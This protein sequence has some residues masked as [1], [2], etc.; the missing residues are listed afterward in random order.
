[1]KLGPHWLRE[2]RFWRPLVDRDVDDELAFHLAMRAELLEGAGLDPQSARDAALQRF[3]D[4]AEV[5]E[6]CI[7]MSHER[8]RRMKRL[9]TWSAVQ[10]HV[11]FAFR[12]LAA[13]PGFAVAVLLMLAL[14]IGATTAV[15]CVV[16]GILLRPLP[17]EQPGQLVD[18]THS[19]AVS[20]RSTVDQ[21]D[22]SF[23]LYRRYATAS[24]ENMGAWRTRGVN[25]GVSGADG[26]PERVAA[27]GVSEGFFP[28]LRI[29][30]VRG[31]VF[32]PEDDRP[33]AP[34]V[35]ILS[36]ALWQ[37]KF[38][39][40]SA[41][42]ER[43]LVVD[44]VEREVVGVM[45]ESF[46]YPE[47]GTSVWFPLALDPSRANP[48]SFNYHVVARL[49]PGVERSTATADLDRY[50]PRLLD[51]F[52]TD[53]PRDM[54]EQAH[55]HP[56]VTP[57]R[58]AV[59]GDVGRLLWILLGAVGL[60]LSIACANVASLFLV[61]AEGAR[62]DLAI[63]MAL[64]AGRGA[65]MAQY[66]SEALVLAVAGGALGVLFAQLGVHALRLSPAGA[67]LP[68]LAEVGIDARVL[69]FAIGITTLSALAVS[70]LPVV[71]SR[72]VA[73]GLV[74]KEASRSATTGRERQRARSTLVVAQ[75][76]LALVLV[77]GSAL[78]ARSFARLRD[79]K[80]GFDASGVL[81]VRV[82]L[83]GAAYAQPAARLRFFE[84][85]LTDIRA[86]PGVRSAAVLDWVPLTDDHDDSVVQIE[87][88]P[89]PAGAVPP[90]LPLTYVS[91]DY[92]ATLGVPLVMGRTF[93][94]PDIDRPSDEVV[95]S[96]ALADR[97][98]KDT[99]PLGKRLRA[100]LSGPWFTIIGVA[101]DVHMQ[102]L[103]LPPEELVYFSI[104]RANENQVAV[105]SGVALAVR[106]T[107][108]PA[109]ISP[110]LRTV[111]QAIDP[112]LPTYDERSMAA[113]LAASAARTRFVMLMLGVAS[114]VAL[115]IGMVGLYGVLAYGVTLRRREIGVRLALGATA[116][117]VTLMVARRG[118]VLA[119][120]G[121]GAG[122]IGALAATRVLH[123]LLYGVSPTDPVALA[124]TCVT[125]FAVAVAASWLPAR[126]AAAIQPMEALRRD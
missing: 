59:V 106:T 54:W 80:P 75:V 50:L 15:F 105:P 63:R 68:R 103:E 23:L 61:R 72:R 28:T 84:R 4:L 76:A 100:S 89:L 37:R 19:I 56:V 74:L 30:P 13:A 43:R 48:A 83:S 9:E 123:G 70:L 126:R 52:P 31:R 120:L 91:P 12:R 32:R 38:G 62:R 67:D 2:R 21:S 77:A 114:L 46:R 49:R 39:S 18:L 53:I 8:E 14:G 25:L 117:D 47:P 22:G 35:M 57:L 108:D 5:R 102:S 11:R 125:L 93:E 64:G 90:D 10:Q 71:R 36:A 41:I 82:A 87:D 109:A 119:A 118:I 66:L 81:T 86:L 42:V 122:L 58:D 7:T 34:P 1:M 65:V 33:G 92:F 99:S 26:I 24:F 88:Q 3:G 6:Q 69:L 113:R 79:V 107:G 51:E 20:G 94:R 111:F 55:V 110:A 29:T 96:R 60:L 124:L 44:G 45:P 78:M 97:Y 95:I 40:D 112:A 116:R 101:D 121:V 17:F 85:A 73:P 98:W 16:D 27:A 115:V 104:A